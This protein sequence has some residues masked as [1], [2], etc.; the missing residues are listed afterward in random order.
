MRKGNNRRV[1]LKHRLKEGERRYPAFIHKNTNSNFSVSFPDLPGCVSVGSSWFEIIANAK[2][3]LQ[4]HIDGMIED[5]E[6][7]PL[8]SSDVSSEK[9]VTTT[10]ISVHVRQ[11]CRQ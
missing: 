11:I 10:L 4:F 6:E 9:N 1:V 8:P 2:E 5:G 7:I 3:A